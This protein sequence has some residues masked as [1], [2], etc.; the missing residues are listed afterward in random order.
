[1]SCDFLY[2]ISEMRNIYA[3]QNIDIEGINKLNNNNN[4][5][6]NSNKANSESPL[7]MHICSLYMMGEYVGLHGRVK[8][9]YTGSK[10]S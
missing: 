8:V 6:N 2:I 9:M 5:N 7:M 10:I 1:M 4:N 3:I